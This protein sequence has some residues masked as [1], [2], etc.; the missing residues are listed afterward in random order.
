MK[1]MQ[2]SVV[3]LSEQINEGMIDSERKRKNGLTEWQCGEKFNTCMHKTFSYN[4]IL[5]KMPKVVTICIIN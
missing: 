5:H 3:W 4:V 2:Q 1:Q